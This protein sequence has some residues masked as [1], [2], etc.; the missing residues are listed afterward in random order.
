MALHR[1][2][3]APIGLEASSYVVHSMALIPSHEIASCRIK[4]SDFSSAFMVGHEPKYAI[5]TLPVTPPEALFEEKLTISMDIWSLGCKLYDIVSDGSLLSAFGG[6][7]YLIEDLVKLLGPLPRPWW[8]RWERREE[9]FTKDGIPV[10]SGYETSTLE[11][12]MCRLRESPSD[13][14]TV[15]EAEATSLGTLL[16]VMLV[17]KPLAR[18]LLGE[19][20][21][22]DYMKNWAEPALVEASF[23]CK[24]I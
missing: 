2:D 17:Y 11:Y 22:S 1:A 20:L 3:N 13:I 6:K 12:R 24:I 4:I 15:S 23:K 14:S 5:T 7:D 10:N 19:A 21:N 9:F 16:S 18:V 8:K